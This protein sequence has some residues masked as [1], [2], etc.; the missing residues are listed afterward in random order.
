MREVGRE[1]GR[2]EGRKE[3]RK[4][5]EMANGST[6]SKVQHVSRW[7]PFSNQY[8]RLTRPQLLYE[9]SQEREKGEEEKLTCCHPE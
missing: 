8:L 2:K 1:V 6:V 5:L 3:G 4:R 7:D 9:K